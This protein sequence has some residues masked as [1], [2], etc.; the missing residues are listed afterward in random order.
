MR[1][2]VTRLVKKQGYGFILAEDGC[3]LYFERKALKGVEMHGMS[4]GQQVE[5]RVQYGARAQ[6]VDISPVPTRRNLW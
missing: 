3:E 4:V 6:A 5:F 2:N 1:G